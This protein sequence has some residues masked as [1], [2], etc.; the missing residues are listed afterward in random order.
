MA[1][2]MLD[3]GMRGC[4]VAALTLEDIDWRNGVIRIP[5]LKT[6]RPY[7]LPLPERLGRAITLYLRKGRPQSEVRT[8]FL[9]H[10]APIGRL[11]LM[12]VHTAMHRAYVGA[13]IPEFGYGCRALRRTVATRLL[14]RGVPLKEIADVLGHQ[15]INTTV[16]YARLDPAALAKVAM[17]WP[18]GLR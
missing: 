18:E 5:N 13:G 11:N 4:D 17:P 1:L 6:G 9:R 10:R 12:S 7:Q 14:R 2:C 15:S 16:R 3:L 8:V